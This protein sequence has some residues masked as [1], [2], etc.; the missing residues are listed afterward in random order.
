MTFKND[1]NLGVVSDG[2]N[3]DDLFFV[4]GNFSESEWE[5]LYTA[6]DRYRR[7]RAPIRWA[8]GKFLVACRRALGWT[9]RPT[10]EEE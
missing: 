5:D 10:A 4:G 6:F 7:A 8:W 2:G 3:H 1:P 9:Y